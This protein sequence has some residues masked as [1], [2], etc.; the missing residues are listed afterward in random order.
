MTAPDGIDELTASVA[1]MVY[2]EKGR[3]S[4][5]VLANDTHEERPW[6]ETFKAAAPYANEEI[7]IELMKELFVEE[8]LRTEEPEDEEGRFWMSAG[9]P[10]T[11]ADWK[12]ALAHL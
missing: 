10:L 2:D 8:L 12:D 4:G 11:E 7:P 1:R 6:K 3:L 9:E 5:I